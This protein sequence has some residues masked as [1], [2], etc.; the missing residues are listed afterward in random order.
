M[1]CLRKS[2][3]VLCLFVLF[4]TA[5]KEQ[6]KEKKDEKA[7]EATASPA[8]PFI[9][10]PIK[11]ADVPYQEYQVDAAKGDTLVYPTGSIILFPPNAFV[12]EAG[13]PV[14]GNVQ[15]KYREFKDPVDF[16]LA[17]IPMQYDSGGVA[18][19]FESSGMF[20]IRAFKDGKPVFVNK[21]SKP[22][23]NIASK[24][25]SN[26]H[27]LYFLDTVQGKWINKGGMQITERSNAKKANKA[28]TVVAVEELPEPVK[29]LKADNK[30]PVLKIE[31]DPSSFKEFAIYKN[32]KFQV[33][34][35]KT[36]FNTKDSEE[37]W[38]NLEL[39][40]GSQPGTYMAKFTNAN[41]SVTYAVKPVFTGSDY[42][43]AVKAF[44]QEY[45]VY[46]KQAAARAAND[47]AAREKYT[48]DS[49]QNDQVLTA[50]DRIERLNAIIM[51]KNRE[52][53]KQNELTG[54][55]NQE[56]TKKN[57][58]IKALQAERDRQKAIAVNEQKKWFTTMTT[59]GDVYRSFSIDN[60]G[61]WNCDIA[62]RQKGVTIKATFKNE[63]GDTL[64]LYH[65]NVINRSM[66]SVLRAQ[67]NEIFVV[68]ASDNMI[69]AVSGN[70]LVYVS[71][72]EFRK[73]K[74]N[75]DTKEV[76]FVMKMVEEANTNYQYIRN[77]FKQ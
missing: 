74:I 61:Y 57:A 63:K 9:K 5:C 8:A 45:A 60:F 24:N 43:N 25:N 29:P 36:R 11:G 62:A 46:K 26:N 54:K 72:D 15:V 38:N 32:L 44:E 2:S 20:D 76:T 39:L 49:I 35:S 28:S 52:I 3:A 55:K 27:S 51:Q 65:I 58:E 67:T 50:N 23:V 13:K 22:E 64:E 19:Q 77:L 16:F 42:D 6:A 37:E 66:N 73:L 75:A 31:V 21:A 48:A 1:N 17:G 18:Y 70:R 33:D 34:E 14:T 12:D 53:E 10:P 30:S 40:K 41:K 47:K 71:Y 4:I 59:L 7:P 69:L 56:I 68:P